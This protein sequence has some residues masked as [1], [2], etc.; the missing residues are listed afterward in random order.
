MNDRALSGLRILD[1]TIL[2]K[3]GVPCGAVPTPARSWT[4]R[5]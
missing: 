3:A 4:T 2:G 5:T 1:L